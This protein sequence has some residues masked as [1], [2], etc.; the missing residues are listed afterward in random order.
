MKIVVLNGSPRVG[1]TSATVNAFAD[2]AKESG[3]EVEILHV[4]KKKINGCLACEYCHMKGEGKCV[5]KDDMDKVYPAYAEAEMLVFASPIYYGS[6]TAQ[7]TAAIQRMYA[8]GKPAKASKAVLLLNSGLGKE[9]K[10]PIATYRDMISA[11]GIE[12]AGVC[13]VSAADCASE[14]KL[15]EIRTFAKGL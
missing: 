12:D 2:G 4:G 8:V 6:M 11:M 10:G 7:L 9:Y 3:H 13:S 1:N 5:Q 15:A 14:E